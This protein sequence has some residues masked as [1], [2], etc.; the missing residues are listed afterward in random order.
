MP[1]TLEAGKEP[2]ASGVS[3]SPRILV[4]IACTDGDTLYLGSAA[5]VGHDYLTFDGNQYKCR[6]AQQ[7]IEAI[8]AMSAQGYDIPGS[9]TLTINDADLSIWTNHISAHAWRGATIT[10]TMTLWD[11]VAGTFSTNSYTWTFI[12]GKPKFNAGK[13]Q[14]TVEAQALTSMTRLKVPSEARSVRCIFTY[15]STAQKT[16]GKDDPTSIYYPCGHSYGLSGGVGNDDGGIPCDYTRQSCVRLGM[17]DVDGSANVT[18]RFSGDTWSAPAQY[19]GRAYTSGQKLYGFNT[20]NPANGNEYYAHV[21]G[22]QWVNC[23]VLEP[24]GEPNSLR[25]E[26][27]VCMAYFGAATILKL[28]VNGVEI[29]YLNR[30]Q[31]FTWRFAGST[32]GGD[33]SRGSG[34][35]NGCVNKD[36]IFDLA[37]GG[38]PHG[39]MCVV[40]FV[41]PSQLASGGKPS[42]Q[43]LVYGPPIA[44]FVDLGGGLFSTNYQYSTNP[45]W[46]LVYLLATLGPFTYAMLDLA[47]F[48]TAAAWCDVS[49]TYTK[50]DGTTATH[51][52]FRSSLV[53]DGSNRK[54]L[55]QAVLETRNCAGIILSKNP[56]TGQLQCSIKRGLADQQPAPITGSNYS[57]GIASVKADGTAGTGYLAY[58]FDGAGSIKKNTLQIDGRSINDTPNRISFRFQNEDNVWSDDSLSQI[59]PNAYVSSGSQIIDV[60]FGVNG[61]PNFDQAARR[62]NVELAEALYGNLRNDAGG[63]E[64]VKFKTTVKA[65]HLASMVGA[66]CGI[67][68]EQLG[69]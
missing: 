19:S 4:R 29:P 14:I 1:F 21:L 48:C 17:F 9:V 38:D 26:A 65:A 18:A 39:S 37:P 30:D 11:A 7:T 61:I 13:G 68:Y 2:S 47:T 40:E 60:P 23:T 8:Q 33:P 15:P 16:A 46:H 56:S 41:V 20:P 34:G 24:A 63:T 45:V 43:A 6:I 36:A 10:L 42:V 25:S 58:A 67:T 55:A 69:F 52:R 44:T 28:L 53:L 62:A 57:T 64:I 31:L 54:S 66:I 22:T 59:D 12:A 3:P 49:I 5:D 32:Q 35:R 50:A 27:V 51:E